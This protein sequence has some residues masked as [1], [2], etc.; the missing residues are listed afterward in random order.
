MTERAKLMCCVPGC[1][2]WSWPRTN[3][4]QLGPLI[5]TEVLCPDHWR[6]IPIAFRRVYRRARNVFFGMTTAANA[7]CCSR[8]WRW[9]R[10]QAIERSVG[11]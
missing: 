7:E 11:I 6:S 9:L 10:R 4:T 2:R 8:L 5:D 1:P 3:Q